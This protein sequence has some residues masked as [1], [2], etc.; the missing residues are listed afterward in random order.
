MNVYTIGHS[1]H[2]I[3][4]FSAMLMGNRIT[5]IWDIRY[6]PNSKW[7]AY[8]QATLDVTCKKLGIRYDHF[9]SLSGWR[10]PSLEDI[11]E[12]RKYGVDLTA[13]RSTFPKARTKGKW[14]VRGLHPYCPVHGFDG[15]KLPGEA[16]ICGGE[17][18]P[19]F[20]DNI[21]LWD[22]QWH[23][24]TGVFWV[25][26]S[27][28]M[29]AA[30]CDKIALLCGEEDWTRCHRSMIA[31]FL[32]YRGVDVTHLSPDATT[33]HSQLGYRLR[34]YHPSILRHWMATRFA[35]PEP[36]APFVPF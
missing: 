11:I 3:T 18:Q 23:M 4:T 8:K 26:M 35:R 30:Q 22:Y 33:L 19:P 28:L 29:Q 16:C 25:G 15:T 7:P 31:D 17:D 9:S 12:Y 2:T 10:K 20:W 14:S 32:M 6:K 36:F 5:K 34:N 21:G 27:C 13:Y 24:L 1:N